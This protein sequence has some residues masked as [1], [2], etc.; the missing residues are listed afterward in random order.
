MSSIAS[1]TQFTNLQLLLLELYAREVE[2]IDLQNINQLIGQ[3]FMDKLSQKASDI[4][5]KNN[6]TAQTFNEWLNDSNQ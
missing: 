6:W 2:E 3:Y 4:A 1:H 5:Q